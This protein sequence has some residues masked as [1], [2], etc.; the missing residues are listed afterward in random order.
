VVALC[1]PQ[2]DSL[3]CVPSRSRRADTRGALIIP[4][5]SFFA[6]NKFINISI[7]SGRGYLAQGGRTPAPTII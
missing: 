1:L 7:V 2:V 4:Q 3:E 5:I 6:Y